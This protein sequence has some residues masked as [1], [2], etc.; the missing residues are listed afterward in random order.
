V[1][2]LATNNKDPLMSDVF[3]IIDGDRRR[4]IIR[5]NKKG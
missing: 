3:E 1:I 4:N 2:A 5:G